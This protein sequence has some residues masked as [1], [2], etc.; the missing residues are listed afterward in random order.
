MYFHCP[1]CNTKYRIDDSKIKGKVLK[2]LC[3]N[4]NS[5]LAIRDPDLGEPLV[6]MF[7][8]QTASI[9]TT[10]T[11][12]SS[13]QAKKISATTQ[14]SQI[15]VPSSMPP[16]QSPAQPKVTQ[17]IQASELK[18][19]LS[20]D[21]AARSTQK[22]LTAQAR[23][24]E[25]S[26][27]AD[28]G[29]AQK[30][31]SSSLPRVQPQNVWFVI[32]KGQRLG[33]FTMEQLKKMMLKSE[34]HERTF[35]WRPTMN[36]WNRL[37]QIAE[38]SSL[39]SETKAAS[40]QIPLPEPPKSRISAG[41]IKPSVQTSPARAQ[42]DL[43]PA[44]KSSP[45]LKSLGQ[46]KPAIKPVTGEEE[47]PPHVAEAPQKP[48]EEPVSKAEEIE[49]KPKPPAEFPRASLLIEE[50]LKEANE[51]EVLFKEEIKTELAA[52]LP[53]SEQKTGERTEELP[54]EKPETS[55]EGKNTEQEAERREESQPDLG[56]SKVER[57][58]FSHKS[59]YT[60]RVQKVDAGFFPS[61]DH[62]QFAQMISL[63]AHA[64][65][66]DQFMH[67][68]EPSRISKKEKQ[69]LI[70][71]FSVMIRMEKQK[72]KYKI[73]LI[74]IAVLIVAGTVYAYFAVLK[75]ASDRDAELEQYKSGSSFEANVFRPTYNIINKRKQEVNNITRSHEEKRKIQIARF[76]SK[77]EKTDLEETDQSLVPAAIPPRSLAS[78]DPELK[79]EYEKLAALDT[80]SSNKQ[81]VVVDFNKALAPEVKKEYQM[82]PKKINDFI[83]GKIKKFSECKFKYAAMDVG[84]KVELNFTIQIDGRVKD[85]SV[86]TQG[87]TRN[88]QLEDCIKSLVNSW[89]FPPMQEPFHVSRILGL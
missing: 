85:L 13:E 68:P 56:D 64:P 36:N 58:F 87:V 57:K 74:S 63:Q 9:R 32:K 12:V 86:E 22:R 5:T 72:S 24:R 84:T 14:P 34:I 18:E 77:E 46:A 37:C 40:S 19:I 7:K 8:T 47:R 49:Q 3:R 82:T 83:V 71:E 80:K 11:S 78:I 73:L 31:E 20:S 4:C 21:D 50:L 53:V 33:P 38:L 66:L 70:R 16:V 60:T 27:Q 23:A 81:E 15:K 39:L 17:V 45:F 65:S 10:M 79:K 76:T 30:T 69:N 25:A 52:P 42:K 6:S 89:I 67:R 75:Q 26:R 51:P 1:T 2:F 29:T 35:M 28:I 44:R 43:K 41:G 88:K 55:A 62:A 61:S 54:A 48:E 59:K